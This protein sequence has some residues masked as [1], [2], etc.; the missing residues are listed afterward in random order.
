[1]LEARMSQLLIPPGRRPQLAV[2]CFAIALDHQNAVAAL[3]VEG[4]YASAIALLRPLFEATVKGAWLA[5]CANETQLERHARGYELEAIPVLI[6]ELLESSLPTLHA[7]LLG[8]FKEGSW[9]TLSSYSHAGTAQVRRWV[10]ANGV[11]PQYT[12][13]ELAEV[14]NIASVMGLFSCMETA[15]LASNQAVLAELEAM[16]LQTGHDGI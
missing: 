8:D 14:A 1:M 15:W 2:A 9:K 16:L 7:K 3:L 5:H 4:R 10:S 12:E 11:E 6:R 13:E